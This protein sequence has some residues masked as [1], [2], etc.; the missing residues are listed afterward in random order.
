MCGQQEIPPR[1]CPIGDEV[2]GNV[3]SFQTQ[4]DHAGF[5]LR[6]VQAVANQSQ[7]M[8]AGKIDRLEILDKISIFYTEFLN[9]LLQQLA[10][11]SVWRNLQ[12]ADCLS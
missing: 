2:C 11:A 3:E 5:N 1:H 12:K 8:L 7:Q 9:V 6:E 4:P 10:I